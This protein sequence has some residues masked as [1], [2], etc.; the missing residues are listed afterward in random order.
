[1]SNQDDVRS[2]KVK[3]QLHFYKD[4]YLD[5]KQSRYSINIYS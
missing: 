1:M 2:R 4:L 5:I 3:K